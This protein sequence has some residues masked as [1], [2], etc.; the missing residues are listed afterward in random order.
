[1]TSGSNIV[2]E[3][4]VELKPVLGPLQ[5]PTIDIIKWFGLKIKWF[6]HLFK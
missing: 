3:P 1:V 4:P 6:K 2:V 5:D